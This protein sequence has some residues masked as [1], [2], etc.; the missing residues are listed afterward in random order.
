LLNESA[1]RRSLVS[2]VVPGELEARRRGWT[3]VREVF[4]DLEPVPQPIRRRWPAAV[5]AA[6]VVLVAA[7][8][9]PPGRAVLGSVRDAIGREKVT[10]VKGAQP[11]L[12]SLPAKGRVLAVSA[13]GPWVVQPD[14]S[15]RLLG[16]YRDASWSPFGK[17]VVATKVNEL[18]TLEP[19]GRLH[20]SIAKPGITGARWGGTKTDTRIAYLSGGALHVI[21]GDGKADRIV[22]PHAAP[23][24]PAWK[25]GD[26]H[27]LAYA[28]RDGHVRIVDSDSGHI[29]GGWAGSPKQLAFSADGALILARGARSLDVYNAIGFHTAHLTGGQFVDAAWAPAAGTL[30]YVTFDPVANR[31][32]VWTVD[33]GGKGTPQQLFGGAGRIGGVTWS[34]DGRWVLASWNSADQWVFVRSGDGATKVVARS[35]ITEQLNGRPGGAF[36]A[37]AGWAP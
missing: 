21:G 6:A 32:T 3:V 33:D 25:A 11:S 8:I 16:G 14:G 36:P 35:S 12:F 28:T 31:S 27:V 22:V 19:G 23:V 29:D 13:R 26:E 24:A 4:E 2:V 37:I 20:W 15:K 1:V 7:S 17:Y 5:A 18:D 30:A 9:T 10:G 34:P